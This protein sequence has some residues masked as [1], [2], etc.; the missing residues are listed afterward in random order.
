MYVEV[1]II[2]FS[3]A[4]EFQQKDNFHFRVPRDDLEITSNNWLI[5][6]I[7]QIFVLRFLRIFI[8]LLH[9]RINGKSPFMAH[10]EIIIM[11]DVMIV[12]IF[13]FLS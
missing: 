5:S 9:V 10:F 11:A 6:S 4:E 12:V 13:F 7:T 8:L 2:F 1:V 3:L